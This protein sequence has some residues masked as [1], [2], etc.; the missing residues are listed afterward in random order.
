[1]RGK[2]REGGS[3]GEGCG[4]RRYL[5]AD[6]PAPPGA[7][8]RK[9]WGVRKNSMAGPAKWAEASV[10]RRSR[11]ARGRAGRWDGGVKPARATAPRADGRGRR[12]ETGRAP[13]RRGGPAR[14]APPETAKSRARRP[15]TRGSAGPSDGGSARAGRPRSGRGAASGRRSAQRPTAAG[16][17]GRNEAPRLAAGAGWSVA[18]APAQRAKLGGGRPRWGRPCERAGRAAPGATVEVVVR[19]RPRRTAGPRGGRADSGER[20]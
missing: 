3:G 16:R 11:A 5:K 15:G 9:D 12:D 13:C 18:R 17:D 14:G 6:H 19:V 10:N 2:K 1:V 4:V 8:R 7:A 20:K